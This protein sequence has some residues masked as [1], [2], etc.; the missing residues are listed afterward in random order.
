MKI[1]FKTLLL[2]LILV[3]VSFAIASVSYALVGD[4]YQDS[5]EDTQVEQDDGDRETESPLEIKR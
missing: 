1:T 3:S 5:V 2:V 4:D